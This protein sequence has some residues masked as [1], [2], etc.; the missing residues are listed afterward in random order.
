MSDETSYGCYVATIVV[1]VGFTL[2]PLSPWSNPSSVVPGGRFL[3]EIEAADCY[4]FALNV[5]FTCMITF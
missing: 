5:F 1:P 4:P 2:T 3:R